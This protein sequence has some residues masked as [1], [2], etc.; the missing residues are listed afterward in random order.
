MKPEMDKNKKKQNRREF[1]I[2]STRKTVL[3]GL[4]FIG[5]SLGYKTVTSESQTTCEVNLPCRNCFKLGSCSED[6]ADEMRQ[7]I[8]KTGQQSSETSGKNNG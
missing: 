8:R 6:R 1:L 4:G 5:V 3:G 7:E 2:S